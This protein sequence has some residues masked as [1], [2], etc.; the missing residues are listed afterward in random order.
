VRHR[1]EGNATR[2]TGHPPR[3]RAT[4]FKSSAHFCLLSI[5]LILDTLFYFM[6][7]MVYRGLI[8]VSLQKR[9]VRTLGPAELSVDIV[10]NRQMKAC[11]EV[12]L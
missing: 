5:A 11:F 2:S 10:H 1:G 3:E 4:Y 6:G 8:S 7:D 12:L 9:L